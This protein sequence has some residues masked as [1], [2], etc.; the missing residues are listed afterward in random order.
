MSTR[1]YS[2][3]T[4]LSIVTLIVVILALIVNPIIPFVQAQNGTDDNPAVFTLDSQP[5][6]VSY[7]EWTAK[8]WQ[9]LLELPSDN[10]PVN[11]QTGKNCAN[12]QKDPN[13]WF[14]PGT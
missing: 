2:K 3:H 7:A 10:N 11:D 13:V 1:G 12:N 8:F 14:I 6:G 4:R 9:W 5:Y